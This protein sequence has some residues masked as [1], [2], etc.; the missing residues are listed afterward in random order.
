M[1]GSWFYIFVVGGGVFSG[2]D[3][4]NNSNVD[5]DNDDNGDTVAGADEDNM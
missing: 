5:A 1:L 3:H 4:V 2:D